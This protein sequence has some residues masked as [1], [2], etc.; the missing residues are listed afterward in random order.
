MRAPTVI[1]ATFV[2][3]ATMAI[4]WRQW[5]YKG[6]TVVQM[7]TKVAMATM[8]LY[9]Y[10]YLLHLHP[11]FNSYTERATWKILDLSTETLLIYPSITVSRSFG[12]VDRWR[13][14]RQMPLAHFSRIGRYGNWTPD[15][16][17]GRPEYVPLHHQPSGCMVLLR[18]LLVYWTCK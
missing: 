8:V 6:H 18:F 1:V 5:W 3:K 17:H 14:H 10:S 9:L 16:L 7:A 12:W 11:G 4:H 15:L 2:L 13:L